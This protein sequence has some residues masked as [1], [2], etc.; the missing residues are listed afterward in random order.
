M[1]E[2]ILKD[3]QEAF[4]L[5]I[6]AIIPVSGG[7]LNQKWRVSTDRG[8]LLVKQYSHERF[9]RRKL[10][11]IEQALERQMIL[12]SEGISCPRVWKAGDAIIRR[13][14][15]EID[16]M[17][18]DFLPGFS[19]GPDT[20]NP[21]QMES[22]GEVCARMHEAFSRLPCEGVKG[23]PLDT[24]RI[25]DSLYETARRGT[26][27]CPPD[28]SEEYREA[29]SELV[30]SLNQLDEGVFARLEQGIAHEDF[31]PDNMLFSEGAVS[32]ILDFDRNQFSYPMHDVGRALMSLAFSGGRMDWEKAAAFQRGYDVVRPLSGEDIRCA[33][34]L[35]WM[36]E[37]SWWIQP[38][39]FEQGSSPKVRRFA[40]EMRY[41]SKNLSDFDV[42]HCK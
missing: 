16:Y 33:L 26:E 4:G 1:D 2:R 7:W 11:E 31:T 42:H 9:N 5:R 22:L 15:D 37:I 21:A 35:T 13:P 34:Y 27:Q 14:A 29:V 10:N 17:V 28:A 12:H 18:M 25:M 20:V 32:A 6:S 8:E 23:Y 19:V 24:Q 41:L 38:A 36:I 3:V 39:C 30:T 40:D